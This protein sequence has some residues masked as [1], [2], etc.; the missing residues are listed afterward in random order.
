ML[1]LTTVKQIH[2]ATR[3]DIG[4][5]TTRRPLPSP[6]LN[7]L[8]ASLFLNHHGPQTYA[9]GNNG[10]PFGPHPHCGFETVTMARPGKL[11]EGQDAEPDNL[12]IVRDRDGARNATNVTVATLSEIGV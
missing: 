5:L 6:T 3:D 9:S 4:D 12:S 7:R 11:A 8:G 1:T 10:L 2:P